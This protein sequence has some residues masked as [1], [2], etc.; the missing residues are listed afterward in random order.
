MD[1]MEHSIVH[2]VNHDNVRFFSNLSIAENYAKEM[3]KVDP[4]KSVLILKTIKSY[5]LPKLPSP[6]VKV[7]N[8]DEILIEAKGTNA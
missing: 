7:F 5:E 4:T 2:E 8:E 6:I 3:I 1:D